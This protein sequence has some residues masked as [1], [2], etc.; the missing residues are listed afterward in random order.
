MFT[1]LGTK[2]IAAAVVGGVS[3]LAL[4]V[5]GSAPA[6]ANDDRS[7]LALG[8]SVVFGYITHAGFEYFNPHNFIGYPDYV[9]QALRFTT[10]NASCPGEAAASFIS[11]AAADNGWHL[12]RASAPLHVSY[13][14]TQ[15]AYATKVLAPNRNTR[16]VAI[17]LGANDGRL[18]L[19]EC[20]SDTQCLTNGLTAIS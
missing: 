7:Y 11:A 17:G 13:T 16:L 14:G 20:G 3:T 8:D 12:Y 6:V 9:S 1:R 18:L 10:T 19:T 15:L 5:A 2:R 4:L